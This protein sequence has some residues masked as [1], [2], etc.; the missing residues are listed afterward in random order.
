M[1]GAGTAV[2]VGTSSR[3]PVGRA[4]AATDAG[5]GTTSAAAP[6]TAAS[7]RLVATG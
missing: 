6:P 4:Q 7:A 1:T 3:R 5:G 2:L